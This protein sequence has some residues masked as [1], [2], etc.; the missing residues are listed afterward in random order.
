M[1]PMFLQ[2][3]IASQP[4][5]AG[6]V[7]GTLHREDDKTQQRSK[8]RQPKLIPATEVRCASGTAD[9]HQKTREQDARHSTR[10]SDRMR[11]HRS[12]ETDQYELAPRLMRLCRNLSESE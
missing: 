9:T 4:V 5:P 8:N 1:I 3:G 11:G 6:R 7:S 2:P 12:L 10:Q